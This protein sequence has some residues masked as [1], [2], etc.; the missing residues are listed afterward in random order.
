MAERACA[1]W[2][3]RRDRAGG[4]VGTGVALAL[5][6]PIPRM[7]ATPLSAVPSPDDARADSFPSGATLFPTRLNR[8]F[9]IVTQRQVVVTDG[10]MMAAALALGLAAIAD[11]ATPQQLLADYAAA[12]QAPNPSFRDFTA[13]RGQELYRLER[14][15]ADGA[16]T[17]C[18]S[19]HTPDPRAAGRA[20]TTGKAIAPLAPATNAER[21]TDTHQVEKWFTRNCNDVLSRP[22]TAL[23]KGDFITYMLSLK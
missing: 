14:A 20:R 6:E 4:V 13:A 10:I 18:A 9:Q 16:L 8:S 22:C 11:A 19:C 5:P 2:R 17:G 15:R 3:R 21:F 12:G 7:P 23:E 1:H